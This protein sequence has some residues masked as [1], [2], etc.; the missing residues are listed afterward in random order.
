MR[1]HLNNPAIVIPFACF[2]TLLLLFQYNRDAV[3]AQIN[4]FFESNPIKVKH[5]NRNISL[6]EESEWLNALN[7]IDYKVWNNKE[8]KGGIDPRVDPFVRLSDSEFENFA[9]IF[10]A[11]KSDQLGV[12]IDSDKYKT[13]NIGLD[14]KGFFVKFGG[15]RI[16]EDEQIGSY[17]VHRINV[18]E[19]YEEVPG[20]SVEDSLKSFVL[21]A[22]YTVEGDE[23]AEINQQLYRLGDLLSKVP[24]I[25]LHRVQLNSVTLIDREG[26]LWELALTSE[27]ETQ[28]NFN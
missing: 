27:G 5:N 26:N 2:A 16:R 11:P 7:L 1:R 19:G 8:F 21:E 17:V 4:A 6:V 14:E 25:A 22:T 18:P 10:D 20:T 9:P 15:D 3:M 23:A 12:E 13:E 28:L 24:A